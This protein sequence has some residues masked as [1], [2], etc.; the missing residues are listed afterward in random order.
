MKKRAVL[1]I[2][3]VILTITFVGCTKKDNK[4]PNN[5]QNQTQNIEIPKEKP[6]N[7]NYDLDKATNDMQSL[8][9]EATRKLEEKEIVQKYNFVG[10]EGAEKNVLISASENN[11]E[12]VAIIKLTD[13]QQ[14]FPVQQILNER[15]EAVKEE[16]IENAEISAIL[17]NSENVKI[18]ILNDIGVLVISTRSDELIQ[19]FDNGI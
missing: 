3:F 19:A 11:Y 1:L 17:S 18:K 9:G 2:A 7:E 5:N 6:L 4:V 15:L 10:L 8:M 14:V 12:E 16:N 13:E